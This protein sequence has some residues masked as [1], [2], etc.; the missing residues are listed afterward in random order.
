MYRTP[1]HLLALPLLSPFALA[2][3]WI[4]APPASL[5]AA[6]DGA[7]DGDRV[8]V[9]PGTYVQT[10]DFHGKA[11]QVIGVGG[12]AVTVLD[13]NGGGAAVSFLTG[14]GP[15]SRLAG[16]TVT[17]GNNGG[18][19][20]ALGAHPTIENCDISLNSGL[21]G[22][23]VHGDPYLLR[24][25]IHNNHAATGHGGG[26]YGAP[27]MEDC[28]VFQNSVTSGAGG[29]LYVTGGAAVLRG[30]RIEANQAV[31]G[32]GRGAGVYVKST[33][34][35]RLER[36]LI[37]A[38]HAN[39]GIFSSYGG[40]LAAEAAGSTLVNCTVLDNTIFG[41][42]ELGGGV[43]GPVTLVDT[44]VRGN[45]LP[46]LTGVTS[47]SYCDVEGGAAGVGNFDADP[48]FVAPLAGDYHLTAGSPCIDAGD[49]AVLDADGSRV[50]VGALPFD[51]PAP[52]VYCTSL[53]NSTGQGARIG[54]SGSTR[55]T[56]N[57]L[58]L[59][60]ASLPAGQPGI[61]FY[62][63][64]QTQVPFV[65][66]LRCVDASGLGLFRLGPP[67]PS[68]PAGVLTRAIDLA[69]PPTGGGPGLVTP[70]STWYFQA[71]FRDPAAAGTG[72]NTSDA[73]RATFVL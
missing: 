25:N 6:V 34:T 43:Y 9:Q 38:N 45:D 39:G 73:L 8:L 50:D 64:A 63:P 26:V 55:M 30:C 46:Q 4:V 53:A 22:G 29:G 52:S 23:G 61:F 48:L 54:W 28:V 13:A 67:A 62:G 7:A 33:G 68:S 12:P 21:W 56:A 11:V 59:S 15:T 10:L 40:G 5:Q 60:A 69:A 18:I 31:F 57:D 36:C 3:D 16:F 14:E 37:L 1:L 65:D 27:V 32:Q 49:P 58:V 2:T 47:V 42:T 20:A 51:A 70:G 24:C 41:N 17:G 72:S 66:G 44:I 19:N 71:W 35:A